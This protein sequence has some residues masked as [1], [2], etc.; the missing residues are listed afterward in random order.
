MTSLLKSKTLGR[1]IRQD[2]LEELGV[3]TWTKIKEAIQSGRQQEA[4]ALV[5]YLNPEGKRLHDV[6]CDFIWACE[7][8]LADNLGEEAV[9]NF[10][11]HAGEPNYKNLQKLTP[12]E[13][14]FL[15][16]ESP[17]LDKQSHPV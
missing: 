12:E 11:R 3:S 4:M 10:L 16:A 7:T 8:Y 17:C 5:D 15:R 6:L 13:Y 2:S 9:Y 1:L 14:V